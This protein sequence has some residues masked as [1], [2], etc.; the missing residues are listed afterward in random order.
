MDNKTS[1][2]GVNRWAVRDLIA[3]WM[4]GQD[5]VFHRHYDVIK[6][7]RFSRYWPFVR[8]IHRSMVNPPRKGQWRGASMFTY[9][10]AGNLRRHRTHYDVTV[11]DACLSQGLCYQTIFRHYIIF[12]IFQNYE[13]TGYL[14]II[15]FIFDR[16]RHSIAAL[17][18]DKYERDSRDYSLY[19]FQNQYFPWRHQSQLGGQF[20]RNWVEKH[21]ANFK[22]R[23][24][25]G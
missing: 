23:K 21:F 25:L 16:C 22:R 19:F 2:H 6:W 7:K 15:S 1:Y 10:E 18:F 4:D 8:G 20:Q 17:T 14:L 5:T 13:N 24:L 3:E 11:M 12:P 9:R